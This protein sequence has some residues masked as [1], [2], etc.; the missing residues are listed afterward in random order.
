MQ[1]I[2]ATLG[3]A[4]PAPEELVVHARHFVEALFH[5]TPSVQARDERRYNAVHGRLRQSR[6]VLVEEPS[7]ANDSP[8]AASDKGAATPTP[9]AA[10]A[11]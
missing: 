2:R 4:N 7:Q 11:S 8:V 1:P 10:P 3:R 5:V 6:A 9:A